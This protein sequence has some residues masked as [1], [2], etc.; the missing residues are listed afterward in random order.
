MGAAQVSGL[1]EVYNHGMD[2]DHTNITEKTWEEEFNI[3]I[4]VSGYYDGIWEGKLRTERIAN[5]QSNDYHVR[6]SARFIQSKIGDYPGLFAHPMGWASSYTNT[7]YFPNYVSQHG[8]VA[9]FCTESPN[10]YLT[11]QSYKYCL[12]RF[13]FGSNWKTTNQL[14]AILRGGYVK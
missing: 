5:Y 8:T 10:M 9:A 2:H 7:T 12:P 14:R 13:T 11:K 3:F 6:L 4:P 1:V